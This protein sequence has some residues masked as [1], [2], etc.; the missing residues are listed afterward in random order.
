MRTSMRPFAATLTVSL[1]ALALMASFTL[2]AWKRI[3]ADASVP[4]L[5][6]GMIASRRLPRWAALLLL[7]VVS[8]LVGAWL[9]VESRSPTLDLQGAVILLGIRA[10]LAPLLMILQIGRVQKALAILEAE[11]GLGPRK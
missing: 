6:N 7:P 2:A 10:T 9:Q 8:F 5:W 1:V 3:P 11:D 4:V